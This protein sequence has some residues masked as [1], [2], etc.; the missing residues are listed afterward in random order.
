MTKLYARPPSAVHTTYI[1][2]CPPKPTSTPN[3]HTTHENTAATEGEAWGVASCQKA[4]DANYPPV[5]H[6]SELAL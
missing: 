4:V 2:L 3:H 5:T 6:F 1:R